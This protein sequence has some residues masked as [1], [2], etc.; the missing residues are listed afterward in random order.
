MMVDKI[1]FI[2][3]VSVNGITQCCLVH[4]AR[5]IERLELNRFDARNK[6]NKR[7]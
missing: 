6:E 1:T 2:V 3:V 5:H 4:Q 7:N